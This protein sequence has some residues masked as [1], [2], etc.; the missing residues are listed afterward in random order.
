MNESKICSCG[1]DFQDHEGPPTRPCLKCDCKDFHRPGAKRGAEDRVR[2][3]AE[4]EARKKA[5]EEALKKAEEEKA[6][7]EV[8]NIVIIE[9]DPVAIHSE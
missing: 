5:E 6:N 1:H 4:K 9:L 7:E 8:D 3:K 2:K